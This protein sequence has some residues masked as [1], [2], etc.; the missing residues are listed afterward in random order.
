MFIKVVP[1]DQHESVLMVKI[2]YFDI[3]I[4]HN[5]CLSLPSKCL[6]WLFC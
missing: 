5:S 3:F 6:S 2:M 1:R 4:T